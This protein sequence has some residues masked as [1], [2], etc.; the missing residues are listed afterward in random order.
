MKRSPSLPARGAGRG[1]SRSTSGGLARYFVR[2]LL[3]LPVATL[4]L[5]TISFALV[6]LI[7]SNPGALLLGD[8]ATPETVAEANRKLGFDKPVHERYWT[9]LQNVARGDLGR[10]YYT[11]EPVFDSILRRL[12]HTFEMVAP[13]LL[14]GLVLGVGLA[15][16]QAINGRSWWARACNVI[17]SFLQAIPEFVIAVLLILLI[18]AILHWAPAPVG[19]IGI[20]DALPPRVTG[21]LF[22]D[23]LLA[24]DLALLSS[25]FH[26]SLLPTLTIG[27]GIA[28]NFAR[29]TRA[30]LTAA[31][32]S[33]HVEFARAA[34]LPRR[35]V[36][37]YALR[38][39]RTPMVTY[40][41]L[42]LA[43]LIG[44]VAIIDTIFSWGGIGSWAI[45]AIQTTDLPAVQGFVLIVS[46][47]S[48]FVFWVFD[49]LVVLLDP[50]IRYGR[51]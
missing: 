31:F 39:A 22:I 41:G 33:G 45:A 36:F 34:G 46:T 26:R 3:F 48:M 37:G 10:S 18:F 5:I 47:M 28:P 51:T 12:P 9:Y 30:N 27:L 7:P 15:V 13:A 35:T 44:G 17:V 24:G 25:E 38:S 21:F 29:V 1:S 8:L 6:N 19:R 32:S 23:T 16:P 11:D 20:A 43:G 14:L 2:R 40:T 42:M 4:I 49:L 50:R